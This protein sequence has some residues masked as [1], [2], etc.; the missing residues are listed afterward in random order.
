MSFLHIANAGQIILTGKEIFFTYSIEQFAALEKSP[1][2]SLELNSISIIGDSNRPLVINDSFE[3]HFETLRL[4]HE[5]YLQPP[6][7]LTS[8][9]FEN[10]SFDKKSYGL[11][12]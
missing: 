5:G 10:C 7:N 11:S 6:I 8:V 9:H 12:I 3:N 1:V 4:T 2:P